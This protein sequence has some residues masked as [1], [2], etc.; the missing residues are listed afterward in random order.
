MLADWCSET[1]PGPK[2]FFHPFKKNNSFNTQAHLK[3]AAKFG[4][5]SHSSVLKLACGAFVTPY[6]KLF[7]KMR[8]AVPRPPPKKLKFFG[9]GRGT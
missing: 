3:G 7:L 1:A 8:Y 2:V 4:L 9:G 6:R 5:T